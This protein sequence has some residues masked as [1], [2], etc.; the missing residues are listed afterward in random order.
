MAQME[1]YCEFL[2]FGTVLVDVLD[3][4]RTGPSIASRDIVLRLM[5]QGRGPTERAS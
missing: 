4:F 2:T 3:E 1:A 5:R